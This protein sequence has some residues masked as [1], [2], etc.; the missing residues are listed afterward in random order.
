MFIYKAR[1]KHDGKVYIGQTDNFQ[2][3]KKNHKTARESRKLTDAIREVGLDSFE[4]FILS[5]VPK[6]NLANRLEHTFI[7]DFR[8]NDPRLGYNTNLPQFTVTDKETDEAIQQ[9]FETLFA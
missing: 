2:Q 8:A 5:E 3:R 6:G 4:W 1:N 7:Q 9:T